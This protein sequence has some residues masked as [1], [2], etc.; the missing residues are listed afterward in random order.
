MSGD[1]YTPADFKAA[2]QTSP[3][4]SAARRTARWIA[5]H[6]VWAVRDELTAKLC[7]ADAETC[8]A[9]EHGRAAGHDDPRR[10][11]PEDR[12]EVG[13]GRGHRAPRQE[14]GRGRQGARLQ[15]ASEPWM[16]NLQTRTSATARSSRSTT[17]PASSWPTSAARTT[18][19]PRPSRSSSPSTTS[20]ARA[21]ASR[22]RRS[23][24]STTSTGID[25]K[26]MTA[27]SMLM[28]VG[29]DFGGDYTPNDADNLERGPVR[30]RNALQF[31]LNIPS[32]KAMADQRPRPR[33]R[34]GPGLRDELPDRQA[35][36]GLALALG[37]QEVRPVDLV[38]AYGTLANG[39][40]GDRPHDDPDRSRTRNGKDVAQRRTCRRPASRS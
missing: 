18:T 9:L 38:T 15:G 27:G 4:C 29:T 33:L 3:S 23:S 8:P 22:A 7:G 40:Q 25:D 36:G 11:A 20:S 6:F 30:V 31:S 10:R 24:R 12:R 2:K 1:Q 5:P 17:R 28:D 34:Q 32:V 19:R 37:V 21:S 16:T 35:N 14:P 26:T 13:P 39:G